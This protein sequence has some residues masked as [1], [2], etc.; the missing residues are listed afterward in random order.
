M[1]HRIARRTL[2]NGLASS[3][4]FATCASATEPAGEVE[5]SRGECYALTATERRSLAP[6][7]AVY[8]GD[9]V[10]TGVQ[11]ALGLHLGDTTEVRLGAEAHLRIDRFLMK[12]GGL[13][14]LERGAMLYDHNANGGP[15]DVTVRSPFGLIAVRGT[16]FFA[17]PSNDVFGVF[18][19][20]GAVTVVGVRTAVLVVSGQ[21]P[22]LRALAREP[23][24]PTAWGAKRIASAMASVS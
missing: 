24:S 1:P 15:S 5:T 2:L 8:V 6:A 4:C 16:R 7:A 13:L 17:G 11:S 22:T 20:R 21:E 12:A 10:G 19:E 18:V 9:A 3:W 23:T 14:L